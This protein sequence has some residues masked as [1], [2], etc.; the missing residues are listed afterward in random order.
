MTDQGLSVATCLE[1]SNSKMQ[2]TNV[3]S[4]NYYENFN[5]PQKLTRF[6]KFY[7]S[8]EAFSTIK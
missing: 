2:Y 1:Y 6:R 8:N 3:L 7:S 5:N 4:V